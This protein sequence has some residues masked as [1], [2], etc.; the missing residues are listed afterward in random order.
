MG[1]K[2]GFGR[3]LLSSAAASTTTAPRP[4]SSPSTKEL[5]TTILNHVRLGRLS[6]AVSILFSSAVPF[7]PSL[8]AHLFR[9]CAS[10]KSIIETRKLES[11]L[12]TF[13]PNPPVFLLNRAIES[14]GKCN[15]LE[16]ARELFD[17]MPTRDGGSWNTMI[18]AYSRNRRPENALAMFSTMVSEGVLASE[19]TFASVLGS[20]AAVLELGLSKQVHGLVVKYGYVGNIILESS[21][22][23]AYGKCGAMIDSRRMFDEIEIPND[24][25]WNVIVRRYLEMGDGYEALR[26]FA[27]MIR[28]N[29][30]PLTF[31]VSNAIL[32]CSSF[33]GL[34][35]GVQIHAFGIKNNLAHDE[36]VSS[37]L[38]SMYAK[39]GDLRSAKK[40]FDLPVSKDQIDYTTMVSG[41][42]L[43]GKLKD[44]R[45]LFDEMPERNVKSW[46]VMLAGYT[47][48]LKWDKALAFIML[49][50]KNT[51]DIDHVTLGLILNVSAAIPDLELGKQVHGYAYR[52]GFHSNLFFGNALLDM[53]GKCGNLKR[54][55]VWFY[56]MSHLR[57]K[58]SWNNLLTSYA[59]HG[60]SE[61]AMSIFWKMLEETKPSKFTFGTLLA[62]C[63][64]IFA[65]GTGKQVHAFMLR[66]G[67]D[68]DIVISGALVD[69]Y[70]KCRCVEY[71][72][73]VFK[74]AHSKDAILFNS[75]ILGCLHNGMG[76]KVVEIFEKMEVERVRPDHTTF[77]GVLWACIGE[78]R[79][80]LGRRYF[81]AMSDKYW[82][83]PRLEHYDSMIEMYGLHGYMDELEVFV[84]N[85]PF[86][87]TVAMLTKVFDFC[88][89]HR[90]VG[91]GEWACG[92]LNELN[93]LVPLRF[94]IIDDL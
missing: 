13:N 47:R 82:L 86:E 49:M 71:A 15:C 30:S 85:M 58:V 20:C 8:Y 10:N 60:L 41:Y 18:T 68:F 52:N 56:E 1:S 57:D 80:E 75:M 12:I 65:L 93:P 33:G 91:L 29:T 66:N 63:A 40:I 48:S 62:A 7:T 74:E 87:P 79:V 59:R 3:T 42:A 21:L 25:S 88:R 27:K 16:D 28:S 84:K 34:K 89:K 4:A 64:N 9:I 92:R 55:R 5:T 72:I 39:F 61:E 69:M 38:I 78:G 44:A 31:T 51:K 77:Q 46:N 70:S 22:V 17:E 53:Y 83:L 6:K 94:E 37:T 90:C 76:E 45:A 26:L 81:D 50:R 67:Y 19:V 32:A 73:R 14:Y 11:H 23:D 36:V 2:T 43:S 54:A 24:V 35:G